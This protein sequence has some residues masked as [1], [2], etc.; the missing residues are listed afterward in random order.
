MDVKKSEGALPSKKSLILTIRKMWRHL[1]PNTSDV[2]HGSPIFKYPTLRKFKTTHLTLFEEKWTK[3]TID[4]FFAHF[5]EQQGDPRFIETNHRVYLV[6]QQNHVFRVYA[7]FDK[8]PP[9]A[10][11]GFVL[12]NEERGVELL[13]PNNSKV[14]C[15]T[16][17][18]ISAGV[19]NETLT[20]NLNERRGVRGS[21]SNK[22]FFKIPYALRFQIYYAN[23]N[24]VHPNA[25]R[26]GPLQA[27]LTGK[28]D[29][30]LYFTDAGGIKY[31]A[32]N[33]I[34]NTEIYF[35][36][37]Y[38]YRETSSTAEVCA[39]Y[40]SPSRWE[41]GAI[42]ETFAGTDVLLWSPM[43]SKILQKLQSEGAVFKLYKN[44]V[45]KDGLDL[46][47]NILRNLEDDAKLHYEQFDDNDILT[48]PVV[49]E[50]EF[51]TGAL[52]RIGAVTVSATTNL[53][54][55]TKPIELEALKI[56]SREVAWFSLPG[57]V[58]PHRLF[59]Q[60]V[61]RR[62][63]L[64]VR[65]LVKEQSGRTFD[66]I[67]WLHLHSF[68][69]DNVCDTR[70]CSPCFFDPKKKIGTTPWWETVLDDVFCNYTIYDEDSVNTAH[71]CPD[72]IPLAFHADARVVPKIEIDEN[73]IVQRLS[74]A[75]SSALS[76]ALSSTEPVQRPISTE[77]TKY[78]FIECTSTLLDTL[79]TYDKR[80]FSMYVDNLNTR[81]LSYVTNRNSIF[82]TCLY[83]IADLQERESHDIRNLLFSCYVD[84]RN[85]SNE[86]V[87][88]LIPYG[89]SVWN[90]IAVEKISDQIALYKFHTKRNE[91][92]AV[93]QVPLHYVSLQNQMYVRFDQNFEESAARAKT[94]VLEIQPFSQKI[95]YPQVQQWDPYKCEIP[96]T[97]EH[98]NS[99]R[100]WLPFE[101]TEYKIWKTLYDKN[102]NRRTIDA[103]LSMALYLSHTDVDSH[104]YWAPCEHFCQEWFQVEFNEVDDGV[105]DDEEPSIFLGE[106]NNTTHWLNHFFVR[107]RPTFF[108]DT[109]MIGGN[110]DNDTYD[111]ED[112]LSRMQHLKDSTNTINMFLT[113]VR[114]FYEDHRQKYSTASGVNKF[115]HITV[116]GTTYQSKLHS[117]TRYHV[118]KKQSENAA[119]R[120]S[121]V[122]MSTM[123]NLQTH[124][125]KCAC[126]YNEDGTSF[127]FCVLKPLIDNNKK[128]SAEIYETINALERSGDV[129]KVKG[130]RIFL[131]WRGEERQ[132]FRDEFSPFCTKE[133]E[134]SRFDIFWSPF[135][136]MQLNDEKGE[137]AIQIIPS[138][139]TGAGPLKSSVQTPSGALL[140]VWKDVD[141]NK[142]TYF[143]RNVDKTADSEQTRQLRG[144]IQPQWRAQDTSFL[145]TSRKNKIKEI[146]GVRTDEELTSYHF[147]RLSNSDASNATL[148]RFRTRQ[149]TTLLGL[150]IVWYLKEPFLS[151]RDPRYKI[152]GL[153]NIQQTFELVFA[154]VQQR[155]CFLK[156]QYDNK[157]RRMT[158]N[159]GV[160]FAR[161]EPIT[162][163]LK[164]I[165]TQ[166]CERSHGICVFRPEQLSDMQPQNPLV[167]FARVPLR[168][169]FHQIT[170]IVSELVPL[171][172]KIT[173]LRVVYETM[174]SEGKTLFSRINQPTSYTLN[175]EFGYITQ[176]SNNQH[177]IHLPYI[178]GMH[179]CFREINDEDVI[180]LTNLPFS[181]FSDEQIK[182]LLFF[183]DS[184]VN[185]RNTIASV[186][187][188]HLLENGDMAIDGANITGFE[189]EHGETVYDYSSSNVTIFAISGSKQ[190]SSIR[191]PSIRKRPEFYNDS[192][193]KFC[194]KFWNQ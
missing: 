97:R 102:S 46:V 18:E 107:N 190:E 52:I 122:H 42:R 51:E 78:D 146:L 79:R 181:N 184:N 151:L 118:V 20:L 60:N 169:L 70:I 58:Y 119:L 126:K 96:F 194:D 139:E 77:G 141:G 47:I 158:G 17:T 40:A 34:H 101:H 106:Y 4:S 129:L 91:N 145:L 68:L 12:Q 114:Q 157:L 161:H 123:L 8:L 7:Q 13:F 154:K 142:Y 84:T 105:E 127:K 135:V 149:S 10:T 26:N 83:D 45:E 152:T 67:F 43:S 31:K 61:R 98:A 56:A 117:Y 134:K 137:Y 176:D 140:C 163:A 19:P 85:I 28:N 110:N 95:D 65:P 15:N 125:T 179:N 21:F 177:L 22:E 62:G 143:F 69:R 71:G 112:F 38:A 90:H 167:T 39:M 5:N 130:H 128:T 59:F 188:F 73:R 63:V 174:K 175:N 80:K 9:T 82:N 111:L 50:H 133:L 147:E 178:R 172:R 93:S 88:C 81:Q 92:L 49:I 156:C 144:E 87:L 132:L 66:S 124:K 160:Q 170:A 109:T 159:E 171:V 180:V 108:D 30:Y 103:D 29:E 191:I 24:G 148:L 55:I 53:H 27:T 100:T 16:Y 187:G 74:S 192:D 75:L 116:N 153:S 185:A 89:V 136:D 57:S 173:D 183:E 99:T 164:I 23:G 6:A 113:D 115:Y 193:R 72:I 162:K 150:A 86:E 3:S 37:E 120:C 2:V 182:T 35:H 33:D 36:A 186:Y 64:C 104:F 138:T 166:L 48:G 121:A 155:S 131:P 44:G 32:R 54:S 1:V 25:F 189:V 165:C 94:F 76:P 14:Y 11:T 41:V 168:S